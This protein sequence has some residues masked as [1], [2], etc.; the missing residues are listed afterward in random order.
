[1]AFFWTQVASRT[2]RVL[3]AIGR[4]RRLVVLLLGIAA[5]WTMLASVGPA[6]QPRRDDRFSPP[7]TTQPRDTRY[8]DP[9]D[10]RYQ[11]A[12][13]RY[14]DPRSPVTRVGYEPAEAPTREE[15]ESILRSLTESENRRRDVLPTDRRNFIPTPTR[16]LNGP[17]REMETARRALIEVSREAD[18]LTTLL[19]EEMRRV[20]GVRPYFDDL[21]RLRARVGILSQRARQY[22]DHEQI[23]PDLKELDK[24]WRLLAYR[25]SQLRGLNTQTI[26][27]IQAINNYAK[28]LG[29]SF[30]IAPQ[31]DERKLL[32]ETAALAADLHNLMEDLEIELPASQQKTAL[33]IAGRRIEQQSAHVYNTV[34]DSRDY[35]D[36]I[37][38]YKNFQQVWYPFATR[39]RPLNNRYVERS[40]R[41]INEIDTRMHELLWLPHQMDREKLLHL[42]SLLKRDVDDFF[43]RAPLKLL[44]DLPNSDQVLS[45]ADQFYGVCEHFTDVVERGE[46]TTE[47]VDAYSYIED[48]WRAFSGVFRNLQ[49]QAAQ[50]VMHEIE[51]NIVALGQALQIEAGGS[52][53]G[54]DRRAALEAAASLDNLANHLNEDMGIWLSRSRDSFRAQALQDSVVFAENARRLHELLTTRASLQEINREIELVNRNWGAVSRWVEQ[55]R[56]ADKPHLDRLSAAIGPVVVELVTTLRY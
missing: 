30:E 40:V 23:R 49:S 19:A 11:P 44:I 26:K 4:Q 22:D 37:A 6:Q 16:P 47:V 8:V 50:Q 10:A 13:D 15:V 20:P 27:Q 45:V 36:V 42:T 43:V 53:Q 51:Q 54:Y 28:E 9:R 33:L 14:R 31:L 17:T 21:L 34:S 24:D 41:R 55:C 38:E 35:R 1:M 12:T 46:Q 32:S 39:L 18:R 48:G 56:T 25:L 3:S 7:I 29:R 5:I 2:N 52:T